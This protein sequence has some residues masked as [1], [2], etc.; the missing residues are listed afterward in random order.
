[1]DIVFLN[2][3]IYQQDRRKLIYVNLQ[4]R[5]LGMKSSLIEF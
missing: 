5:R 4:V 2:L 1:M 3:F